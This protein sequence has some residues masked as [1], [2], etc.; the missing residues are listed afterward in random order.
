[1]TIAVIVH[2]IRRPI[3]H[4]RQLIT[5]RVNTGRSQ[6]LT[7]EFTDDACIDLAQRFQEITG[8]A[9]TF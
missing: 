5:E 3:G 7:H 6:L 1:M 9:F 2:S 8:K 4:D